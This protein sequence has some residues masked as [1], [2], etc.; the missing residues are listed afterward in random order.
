[1]EEKKFTLFYEDSGGKGVPVVLL[2]GYP[3]DHSIWN[4]IIPLLKSTRIIAPDLRGMGHSPVL[5]GTATMRDMAE[6]IAYLLDSLQIEQAVIVGHSMGG[7]V[8]LAFAHAFP[9]RLLGLGL[10]ATQARPDSTE[11]RQA[12]L[13]SAEE[14]SRKGVKVVA[15]AMLPKLTVR[16]DVSSAISDIILRTHPMGIMS[17][18]RGMAEREDAQEWL[19]EITVPTVVVAG[20]QDLLMPLDRSKEMV[21][22]LNRAWLVEIPN[23]GH[24][25]MM[26]EPQ[27]VADAILALLQKIPF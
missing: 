19:S 26:E 4:S 24:M 21:R 13:K 7:Y 9:H 6:D 27:A 25:P 1:M 16:E 2:H 18:L 23:A 3:L 12:R 17:V 11:G 20:S 8:A 14:V 5:T 10:V 15:E 22:L